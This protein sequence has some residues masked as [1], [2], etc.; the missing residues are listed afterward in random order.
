[1]MIPVYQYRY[2]GDEAWIDGIPDDADGHRP[3]ERRV[4]YMKLGETN[5][6]S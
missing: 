2:H 6:R 1:M 4:L 3:Y 5:D